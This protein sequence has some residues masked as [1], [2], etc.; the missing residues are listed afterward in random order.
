[1]AEGDREPP[2]TPITTQPIGSPPS[3]ATSSSEPV[4]GNKKFN[5][6]EQLKADFGRLFNQM[7]LDPI[8]HEFL[9]AR[10][11]DQVL[12]ME[13]RAARARD[14]YYQLR[15]VTIIGGVILPALVTLAGP[16]ING[17][18]MNDD[19]RRVLGW[20]TFLISQ[21]VA[22]SAATE[23]FFNYGERWR[24]YRRS[25]EL[26]K[27]QGWQ[28]FQLSGSY[29]TYRATSRNHREAFPLFASQIEE[30][31]QR[32]VEVYASQV[33]QEKRQDEKVDKLSES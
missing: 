3:E 8:Q 29:S 9:K 17:A 11:L 30:I 20:S 26:L 10:W 6:N 23:Q 16:G 14:R 25:V 22:I 4:T 7:D 15:L 24:H 13:K 2:V 12:W 18:G 27:S 33:T 1:M 31:I 28:F 19:A 5:Y 21:A 32:D